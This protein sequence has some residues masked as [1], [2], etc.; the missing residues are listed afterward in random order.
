VS[1]PPSWFIACPAI[2]SPYYIS[3]R[4][5]HQ[6]EDHLQWCWGCYHR[7][8]PPTPTLRGAGPSELCNNCLNDLRRTESENHQ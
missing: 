5:P 1:D 3:N 8:S 4:Q 6:E 7:S 2:L